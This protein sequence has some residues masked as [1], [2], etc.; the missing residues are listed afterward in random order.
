MR[1]RMAVFI[2][3]IQVILFAA[4]WFVYATW[5]S[6][7]GTANAPGSSAAKIILVLLSVS[8][9][10]TSLLAFS[11]SNILIRILYTIS[12]VWLGMLSFLFLAASLS[13]LS[14]AATVLLGLPFHK[15]TIA[16]LFFA[17]AAFASTYAIINALFIRVRRISVKLPNLPESWRGRVAALVSDVHLGHVRGHGFTQR[18]VHMLLRL[19]PDVVF[20]TGDLFDGTSANLERVAK[21]WVHLTPPLGA[22]FVTGNHEEFSNQSKYLYPV[23]TPPIPVLHNEKVSL[24]GLDLVGVHHG[25]LFHSEGFRSILRKT[26]PVP[27]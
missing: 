11:Y 9:V 7:T 10:I 1:G 25:A 12:A 17:V 13:W 2:S 27:H 23:P 3:I 21:P 15:Q 19:R 6:F 14:Y 22:F 18:I 20:I 24:A 4:H 5:M 8:F 16:L 26:S